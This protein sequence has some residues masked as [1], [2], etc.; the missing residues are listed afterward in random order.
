MGFSWDVPSI[1]WEHWRPD[2]YLATQALMIY[3]YR[4]EN[5][6]IVPLGK[7]V[8]YFGAFYIPQVD[9]IVMSK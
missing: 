4:M 2:Y 6:S 8:K 5:V 1:T 3:L 9:S 7:D